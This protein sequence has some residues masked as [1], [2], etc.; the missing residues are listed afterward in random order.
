MADFKDLVTDEAHES[1]PPSPDQV[2][3]GAAHGLCV[4]CEGH[5]NTSH[6]DSLGNE[7]VEVCDSPLHAAIVRWS[8][9]AAQPS[10]KRPLG[11]WTA[12]SHESTGFC[13]CGAWH[14]DPAS[15]PDYEWEAWWNDFGDTETPAPE[16]A[17]MTS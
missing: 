11:E 1:A 15:W 4:A 10:P 12:M 6:W 14:G 8:K 9:K 2:R 16:R 13:F 3:I 7:T 17:G 5:G